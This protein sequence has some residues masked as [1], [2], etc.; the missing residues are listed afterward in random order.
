LL[1]FEKLLKGSAEKEA[2]PRRRTVHLA[3]SFD[4]KEPF[5]S[6]SNLKL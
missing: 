3:G 2:E 5:E 1:G 4:K 6:A